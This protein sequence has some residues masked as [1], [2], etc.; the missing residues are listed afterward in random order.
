M[1]QSPVSRKSL[2]VSASN[3]I[4]TSSENKRNEKPAPVQIH[5]PSYFLW[6]N[7][8]YYLLLFPFKISVQQNQNESCYY[9]HH[10]KFQRVRNDV[11]MLR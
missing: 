3:L 2:T 4:C 11:Y 8:S 9:V 10:N 6:I 1:K 7:I 5:I